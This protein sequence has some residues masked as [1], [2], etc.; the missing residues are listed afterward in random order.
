MLYT[1]VSLVTL[2]AAVAGSTSAWLASKHTSRQKEPKLLG[3]MA[4]SRSEAE[5]ADKAET[6]LQEAKKGS[7]T[8]SAMSEG[9]EPRKGPQAS[10]DW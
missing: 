9:Q 4:D 5:N 2:P 7:M 8:T 10:G 1:K 6:A 3:K